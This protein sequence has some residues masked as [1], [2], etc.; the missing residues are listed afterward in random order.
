VKHVAVVPVTGLDASTRCAL[1]YAGTLTRRVVALHVVDGAT[2]ELIEAWG[3]QAHDVPL[4]VLEASSSPSDVLLQAIEVLK[5]T[6]HADRVTV[7]LP[8][9]ARADDLPRV[10]H[11]GVS[12]REVPGALRQQ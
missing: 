1:R 10:L 8:P 11:P 7:V 2:A 9:A 3:T 12:V 4:V 5:G 6:E